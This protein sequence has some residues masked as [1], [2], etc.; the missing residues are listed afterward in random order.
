MSPEKC[1]I[2]DLWI[3]EKHFHGK[4]NQLFRAETFPSSIFHLQR[5]F[6]EKD[7]LFL[8]LFQFFFRA[9]RTILNGSFLYFQLLIMV[10]KVFWSYFIALIIRLHS[11]HTVLAW[12]IHLDELEVGLQNDSGKRDF[13]S[14]LFSN[15]PTPEL[16]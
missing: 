4:K 14:S 5:H 6:Y 12:M 7:H 11:Q 9:P 1:K 13:V 10:D 2:W 3:I 16:L 15:P 8:S